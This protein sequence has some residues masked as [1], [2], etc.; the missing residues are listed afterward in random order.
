MDLPDTSNMTTSAYRVDQ[1]H[2]TL[3]IQLVVY[4]VALSLER[5]IRL[6]DD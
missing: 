3:P 5:A 4:W 2:A 6:Y 1:W